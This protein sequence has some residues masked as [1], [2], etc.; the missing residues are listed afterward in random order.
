MKYQLALHIFRRDLR[1]EDN[2]ALIEALKT[3]AQVIP[4]FILDTR[5]I[6]KNPYKSHHCI[7]FM[8]NSLAELDSALQKQGGNLHVF[9]GIAEKIIE[10]ILIKY[11]IQAVFF[12][13]DYTPFSLERDKHILEACSKHQVA[14]HI[15]A[16]TLLNEPEEIYKANH[17]PYTIFT[18]FFNKASQIPVKAPKKNSFSNF[19]KKCLSLEDKFTLKRLL[20]KKNYNLK[21]I[22]GRKEA[23][24]LLKKMQDLMHYEITRNYP[25]QAGTTYLSAHN[26]FGTISVRE[27]YKAIINTFGNKHQLIQELYWRDFFTHIAFHF[28]HV[29]GKSFHEKFNHLAWSKSENHFRAWCN[30]LTG[31]PIV[32]AGMRELNVTGYMHNRSRMIVASFLTK[33]LHIDWRWGEKYFAQQLVDYDPAVNNGNWQWAASTGCDAVPYFRIFNPWLQQQRFDPD[34]LYI[35]RWIPELASFTPKAIHHLNKQTITFTNY[36]RPIVDHLKESQ[37]AKTMYAKLS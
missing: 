18:P 33:D 14:C 24:K 4:C 10:E 5:Q 11:K 3:S 12:N 13:R 26:K 27:F 25:A 9:H 6:E 7:Q 31:V 2:T 35:K 37:K 19:Y 30:G 17:E 36:P 32:D 16:D 21:V 1:L 15:Y 22:G 8:A 23:L 20:L 34:C 29:F 28:P